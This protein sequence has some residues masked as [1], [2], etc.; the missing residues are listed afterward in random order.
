MVIVIG[1]KTGLD[2]VKIQNDQKQS[3]K[4]DKMKWM[5]NKSRAAQQYLDTSKQKREQKGN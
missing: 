3:K 5:S 4:N 2:V 1:L